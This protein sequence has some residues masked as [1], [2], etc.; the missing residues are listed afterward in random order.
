MVKITVSIYYRD[1]GVEKKQK[2]KGW[3]ATWIYKE[4]SC[5]VENVEGTQG[6]KAEE[7]RRV[8]ES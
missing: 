8:P 1:A 3:E 5:G 2:K 6:G 4:N 7:K